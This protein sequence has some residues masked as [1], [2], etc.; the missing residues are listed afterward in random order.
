MSKQLATKGQGKRAARRP[1]E[2]V[3]SPEFI[4]QDA[5]AAK[6]FLD[7]KLTVEI[8]EKVARRHSMKA[9]EKERALRRLRYERIALNLAALR[10]CFPVAHDDA[11]RER[12]DQW[13]R[14]QLSR[15][16]V[17]AHSFAGKGG[18]I[19]EV[20]RIRIRAR[21]FKMVAIN[22][23]S[24]RKQVDAAWRRLLNPKVGVF[25]RSKS[26]RKKSPNKMLLDDRW[27][28]TPRG[29]KWLERIVIEEALR[30]YAGT[31]LMG[32]AIPPGRKPLTPEQKREP[33]RIKPKV[34]NRE[35]V[36]NLAVEWLRDK[37][38][39][40]AFLVELLATYDKLAREHYSARVMT[41]QAMIGGLL[42]TE[43]ADSELKMRIDVFASKP[44]PD[45]LLNKIKGE[46]R[47]TGRSKGK[48]GTSPLG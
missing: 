14:D 41:A 45:S 38:S 32:N 40:V 28:M 7:E 2:A 48:G 34:L 37:A 8:G 47:A 6:E 5:K 16:P 24:L 4:E 13:R 29:K 1:R 44:A 43:F 27:K 39:L 35:L 22:H 23:G 20:E 31:E 19:P 33:Q 42:K 11:E 30:W 10:P 25:I 3:R 17:A 12:Q 26:A 15:L 36:S 21:Y 18:V 9:P 46:I